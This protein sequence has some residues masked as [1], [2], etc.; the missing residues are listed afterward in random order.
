RDPPAAGPRKSGPLPEHLGGGTRRMT[1]AA[2]LGAALVHHGL[3]VLATALAGLSWTGAGSLVVRWLAPGRSAAP[4]LAVRLLTGC[5]I[6]SLPL[7]GLALCGVATAPVVLAASLWP[8]AIP[9]TM[10]ACREDFAAVPWPSAW[11]LPLAA[12]AVPL[13]LVALVALAPDFNTDVLSFHLAV[14]EQM[15]RVHK[16]T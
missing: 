1:V 14:P 10:R 4:R 16:L 6:Q 13:A 9:W 8:L 5:G 7:L 15:L 3:L 12:A 11:R 2:R